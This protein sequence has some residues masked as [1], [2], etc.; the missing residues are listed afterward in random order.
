[1]FAYISLKIG[2]FELGHDH[3]AT[4]TS[5]LKCW[6]LFRYVWKEEIPKLYYGTNEMYGGGSFSSW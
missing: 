5:Y 6:Y 3:D 2:Y 4:L 1:M